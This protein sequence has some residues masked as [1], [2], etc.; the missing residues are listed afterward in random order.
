MEAGPWGFNQGYPRGRQVPAQPSRG[1]PG[2]Q[3]GEVP[4]AGIDPRPSV[5]DMNIPTSGLTSA[6]HG[7]RLV[8][9]MSL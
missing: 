6:S 2:Q 1:L 8:S 9:A 7:L 3:T 4:E 5:W